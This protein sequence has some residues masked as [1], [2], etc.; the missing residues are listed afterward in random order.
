VLTLLC[1]S[2]IIDT[3]PSPY[4]IIG[5][6]DRLS[7][8]IFIYLWQLRTLLAGLNVTT[9]LLCQVP[10][11]MLCVVLLHKL[12]WPALSRLLYPLASRKVITNRKALISV[13]SLCL[14]YALN[15][16]QVGVKD[17]LKLF[18]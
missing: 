13:G 12:I 1:L 15:V 9:A 4:F 8:E 2:L 7:T 18:S 6:D 10:A 3:R 11:I 5:G 17:V 14:L 16:A